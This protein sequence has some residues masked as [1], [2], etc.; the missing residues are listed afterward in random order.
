MTSWSS[1]C[2]VLNTLLWFPVGHFVSDR[3]WHQRSYWFWN[4]EACRLSDWILSIQCL[5]ISDRRKTPRRRQLVPVACPERWSLQEIAGKGGKILTGTDS[6]IRFRH[7]ELKDTKKYRKRELTL[8]AIVAKEEKSKSKPR[9]QGFK[10]KH[11]I[12][13]VMSWSSDQ[14]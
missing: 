5:S 4:F 1:I 2:T 13:A 7:E 12:A 6:M 14:N 9:Q 11:L 10:W 8:K 3:G